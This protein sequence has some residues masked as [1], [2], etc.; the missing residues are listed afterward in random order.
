MTD[1]AQKILLVDDEEK[2]LNSIAERLKLLGFDPL[3]ASS[4]RQALELAKNNR[5]D[6]AI[7]DL[8]MP[9]MDGLV[10]I[11]KLK[12][13]YSD[14]RSVLLTGHGNEKIK[15]ATEALKADY[16]EKDQMEAFWN[17]IKR[18]NRS[19]NTIV[20]R[21]PSAT[22]PAGDSELERLGLA[23]VDFPGSP[24]PRLAECLLALACERFEIREIEHRSQ[25]LIFGLVSRL[26][27]DDAIGEQKPGGRLKVY[28][29]RLEL[30]GAGT[31]P[32]R[33]LTLA[34]Q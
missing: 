7:V 26:F 30:R 4:G 13:I 23:L 2:F 15:Q 10:T 6:M 11:T 19:G 21:P 28:A 8:K 18:S 31:V 9:D 22:L 29:D 3:K 5:I 17:F 27:V 24:V 1:K 34:P 14:L 20:I 16:F 12:E 25:S 33:T 32:S